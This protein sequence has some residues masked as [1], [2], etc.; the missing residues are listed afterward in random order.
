MPSRT[1]LWLNRLATAAI[2]L[3]AVLLVYRRLAF[4]NQILARGDT[5]LYFYP[6]WH[7][8]AEALRAGRIPLWNP[9]LFMGAP[10]LANSQVGFFYPLN[11]PLWLLLRTPYAVSATIVLHVFIASLGMY[12]LGRRGMDFG[13][14]AAILSALLF[15]MGGYISAQV[16]HVNQLQ[17]LAWMPWLMLAVS[18]WQL[19]TS[20]WQRALRRSAMIALFFALQLLAGHTQTTFISGIGIGIWTGVQFLLLPREGDSPWLRR[21]GAGLAIALGAMMVGVVVAVMI[22]GA[23]LLPT[24]ELTGLSRQQGGLPIDEALSFSLHPLLFARA[25]LP[26]YG[27]L[28]F[29][30]YIAYV[31]V[32][33][34]VLAIVGIANREQRR[35]LWPA[36]ALMAFGLFCAFG[37]FNPIFRD[38]IIKLPGFSLFRVP[39]RWLVLYG[40]G[41]AV[42][43]GA[44][45]QVISSQLSAVSG[46]PERETTSNTLRQEQDGAQY[47][48]RTTQSFRGLWSVVC[49]LLIA[50]ALMIAVPY[51]A[52]LGLTTVPMPPESPAEVPRFT[53]WIGWLG[54]V[55]MVLLVV[56]MAG[57]LRQARWLLWLPIMAGLVWGQRTLLNG[58]LTTPEAYSDVRAA[59]ARL[60][61]SAEKAR[62]ANQP[63]PRFLSISKGFF[64]PGDQAELTTIYADQLSEEAQYRFTVTTKDRE[65]IV[66][67]LS[68][69]FGLSAIDGFDGGLLPLGDYVSAVSVMLPEGVTTVDGRLREF[70]E[71][72]PDERWLDLFGV[73]HLI[74]DRTVDVFY[75]SGE[76]NV[77]FDLQQ[78]ILL[79]P[80]ETLPIGHSPRYESTELW[81]IAEGEPGI[82]QIV[83]NGTT[84]DVQTEII[85]G[86]VSATGESTENRAEN[87]YRASWPQ[88]LQPDRI[89][90]VA[91]N[92]EWLIAGAS[93]VDNRPPYTFRQVVPGNYRI[94]HL[95]DVRIYENL[96]VLPRAFVVNQWQYAPDLASAVDTLGQIDVRQSAVIEGEGVDQ[97]VASGGEGDSA[98]IISYAPE[99]IELTATTQTPSLLVLTEAY[100]PGWRVLVNDEPSD[101]YK[102]NGMFRGVF[103][104][105]G[106]N[107]ITFSYQPASLRN[108]FILSST[109]IVALM[110]LSVIAGRISKRK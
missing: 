15:G 104:P 30:E 1:Q 5:Y 54:E 9:D 44:G 36:L 34:L 46:Q 100:Y 33:G 21:F 67:N 87:I 109:G 89:E 10:L 94:A 86:Q 26:T 42:C 48:I 39:A 93:L 103:L 59:V 25:L 20:H 64:D 6:Y 4:S 47:A 65:I 80:G 98:E 23:Q 28:P 74:T 17:G 52:E 84:I 51:S 105:T 70:L 62:A 82:V 37:E 92:G 78:R 83:H 90:L 7:A 102:V 22:A 99:R 95:G 32:T 18:N 77:F 107:D 60:M 53:L 56:G 49:G 68:L 29:S 66:P 13:R 38:Y 50:L 14:S 69:S 8:A 58:A 110:I 24:L 19:A 61:V 45:W 2:L 91:G 76:N 75:R 40:F 85:P 55:A 79:T 57:R 73:Q 101:I 31:P 97:V 41:V 16:E 35:R 106:T 81:I 11:W 12:L 27:Q 63:V 43:A 88:S 96:D 72:V 108:G 71:I 3:L